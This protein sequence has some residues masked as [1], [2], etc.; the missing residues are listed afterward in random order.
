MTSR[1]ILIVS[2]DGGGNAMP[3]YHLGQRLLQ[4]GHD[5][6]LLGWIDQARSA[7]SAGLPFT[8]YPSVPPWPPG[9]AQDD[10]LDVLFDYLT[11][12]LTRAEIAAV[13]EDLRPD[14][15]V[16]DGMMQAAYD[17]ARDSG[18]PTISLCHLLA[19]LFS[20]PWGE[21]VMGRPVAELFDGVDRVLALTQQAFDEPGAHAAVTYVGPITRPGHQST[22]DGLA[23]A[24]L[25]DLLTP[26]DPWVLASLST[27][28]QNQHAVI[29]TLLDRM[30]DLPVRV[31]LTLGG[32]VEPEHVVAPSNVQVRSFVAHE[33]V[34]P[35]MSLSVTHGGLSGISTV[36][37]YGVPLV[38]LPQGRDQH[39]NAARVVACGVG[40]CTEVGGVG[41]AVRSVLGN[42]SYAE[43]ASAFKDR[44]AGQEATR[45]VETVA[46][47][48]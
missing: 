26:G 11:R 43:A 36:L 41:S 31:L 39:F 35:F 4:A 2:W 9:V 22:P 15:L 40:A 13:I 34:L 5:V 33:E 45:I 29:P 28:Q 8:A 25:S 20:G 48:S 27:T 44:R 21:M 47:G 42:A 6:H 17:A 14:V 23:A 30:A 10:R 16:I 3:A 37:A 19:S 12:D 18:L 7:A 1:R 32:A 24:G 38:C 46:I